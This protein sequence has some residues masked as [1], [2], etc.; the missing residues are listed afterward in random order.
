MGG[1]FREEVL[2]AQRGQWMGAINLATP[3]SFI[4]WA[5]LAASLAAAIILFLIF[6]HYT[7]RETVSGQLQP[8]AGVL[9]LTAQ[10]TSTVTRAL[11]HEGEY[12]K[13][14]Q[15]LVQVSSN[16]ISSMGDT[17]VVVSAQLRAQEAQ[18]RTT[19]SE[20]QPQAAAQ[21]KDLQTR[22]GMLAAQV[23]QIDGQ[24][25]LAR[26]Q[27]ETANAFLGKIRPVLD[28]G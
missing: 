23:R 10:T 15:P 1:L 24:L 4:W 17:H 22:I 6:G 25:A 18:V 11:V 2:Q 19:L 21:T 14:G 26:T 28:K 27:T 3:L 13:A 8:S 16:L 20:L 9:T 5:L 12:V 7:R